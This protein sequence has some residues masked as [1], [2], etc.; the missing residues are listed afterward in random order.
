M[1]VV[2]FNGSP[3]KDGNT[4]EALKAVAAELEKENIEVEI[5]HVGNKVIRGC[6]ACGGCKRNM[7]E[8]CVVENDPVNDWVQKMKEADGIILGSPVHYSAIAGTM[9][10]FLD[11]AFYVSS[12]NNGMLRHKV[13]ASVVAVRRSGGVPTFDQLNHYINYSEMLMPSSNYWNVIHGTA[14]GEAHQDEE[15]M[16]IMRVLGKNMAWL[17]KLTESNKDSVI[18][19]PRENKV[20]TNFIR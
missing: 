12:V 10:S 11:R 16:Q 14:K 7:N 13:G 8:R 4:Y 5:I 1:K 6:L 17:L 19:H 3:N 2:A 18:S 20:Y 15:G 9:K